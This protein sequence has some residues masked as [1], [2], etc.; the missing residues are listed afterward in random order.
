M[1]REQIANDGRTTVEM[2]TDIVM[3]EVAEDLSFVEIAE[4]APQIGNMEFI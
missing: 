4:L 2:N 1:W 3:E